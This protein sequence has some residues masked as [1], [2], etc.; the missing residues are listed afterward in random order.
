MESAISTSLEQ[1][2]KL[3][4]DVSTTESH[5]AQLES[6]VKT[7]YQDLQTIDNDLAIS[8]TINN[9]LKQLD[10]ALNEAVELLEVVSI[11]PEIGSEAS[12]L[13][14]VISAFK[15]PVDEALVVSNKVESV[16]GPIRNAIGKV[17]PKIKQIDTILLKLMNAENQF[18]STLGGAIQCINSLPN[19]SIKSS[20]ERELDDAAE[21][22]DP[23]VLKFDAQQVTILSA[24]SKA[25]EEAEDIKHLVM[26]L[27]SLQN[28]INAVMNVLNPL[29][30]SLNAVKNVLGHTIRVPYGG[31]PK[32]CTKKVLGLP[33]KY[34][35]GWHTVYFSFSVEQIIKG[36]LHVLGPVMDLLNKAMNAVL[37][38]V[39][40]ALH[41][42]I[43][44][45]QI[46]GLSILND[47]SNDLTSFE[48]EIITP[49]D[50]LVNDL[51]EFEDAYN[52][53]ENFIG[54]IEKIN[55]ACSIAATS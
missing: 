44:L 35:C 46:P 52:S 1:A 33:V 31:Y 54:E 14:N 37:Q 18:I 50:N 11:I 17:E 42:N 16:V 13:K 20:L 55:K 10:S 34:P 3:M 2:H 28:Q 23:I 43:N 36:G 15:K 39:L 25:S 30:A 8:Q 12:E 40:R 21:N 38:P 32:F 45:P 27:A 6:D 47:L 26:G 48:G 29:I 7:V 53:V 4:N 22:V 41:L 19:S 24:I 5:T 51:N 49:I 9:D